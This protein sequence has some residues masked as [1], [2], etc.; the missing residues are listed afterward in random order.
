MT[1]IFSNK[2]W[3]WF[4][5]FSVVM[6]IDMITTIIFV[7]KWGIL[8]EKN[9]NVINLFLRYSYG[10]MIVIFFISIAMIFFIIFLTFFYENKNKFNNILRN[11]CLTPLLIYYSSVAINNLKYLILN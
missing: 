2:F 4:S 9:T 1:K 5:L 8:Y 11:I 7:N 3:K 6:F 10:S